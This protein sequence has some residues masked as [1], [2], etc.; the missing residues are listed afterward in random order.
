MRP[1]G[2]S[3]GPPRSRSPG[4]NPHLVLVIDGCPPLRV[5]WVQLGVPSGKPQQHPSL[6]VHPKL[7]AQVLLRGLAGSDEWDQV[8]LA[9]SHPPGRQLAVP[10]PEQRKE[11]PRTGK[12]EAVPTWALESNRAAHSN[13]LSCGQ[14][15][16][17]G[18]A[19]KGT[20]SHAH[21]IVTSTPE[22]SVPQWVL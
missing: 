2:Q 9:G 15:A 20:R 10:R 12:E 4:P 8:L 16:R 17:M 7:G 5:I 11:G 19:P 18:A 14:K 6:Q 22:T 1:G 21:P 3:L 13:T